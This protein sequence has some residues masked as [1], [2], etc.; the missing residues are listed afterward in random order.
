MFI[1][2][3]KDNNMKKIILFAI[4]LFGL[5]SCKKAESNTN[6][7]SNPN[8]IKVPTADKDANGC[9]ISAGFIWSKINKD[10][11]KLFTGISLNPVGNPNN[12]DETLCTYI[13]FDE[14]GNVAE[15][16]FPNNDNSILLERTSKNVPWKKDNLE[17]ISKDGFVLKKDGKVIFSGDGE[18]GSK[19][20]GSNDSEE[21]LGGE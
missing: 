8:V 4:V 10:C 21:E 6:D 19:V 20:T 11:M 7:T 16:F 17:L 15:A 13:L 9:L 18:I 5:L 14:S 2:K 3:N 12:E 1:Q